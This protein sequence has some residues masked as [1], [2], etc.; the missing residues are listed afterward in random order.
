MGSWSLK[1]RDIKKYPHFDSLISAQEAQALATDQVR[2]AK[3]A[4]FPFIR[5]VQRWNRFAKKGGKGKTK[6]RPI[7]YAARRDASIYSYYRHLL[8][9]R[10]ETELGRLGLSTSILAYRRIVGIEGE[11]GKCNIHFARDAILKIRELRNCCVVAL[12]ISGFFEHLDHARLKALWCR[13]LG[14][15]RLPPDHFRVFEAITRYAVVDKKDAYERLGYI[16]EKRKTKAGNPIHGYLKPY[17]KMPKQLCTG[18]EF[19]EKLVGTG[20]K[21]SIIQKNFKPFGIPQGAPISDLLANLYLLDFDCD[22]AKWVHALGGV[23]YRYSDDILIIVPGSEPVGS[24][25]SARV[26]AH[27]RNF[28]DHLVIKEEKSSVFAFQQ[29][30]AGQEFRLISGQQGR[31]GIEYLG[32]RYDGRRVYIRDATLSNLRRKVARGA[33]RDANVA[34][35]RYPD[36]GISYLKARFDYERL[37]ARFGRVEDFDEK[38]DDYRHWTFW[39]YATRAVEVFGSIGK[40]IR[41]QLKR[42]RSLIRV[43]ADKECTG[44]VIG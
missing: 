30:G 28:G 33:R 18:K 7:R 44:T 31:N 24:D 41:D 17:H 27:I 19:R 43:R 32:F 36:K 9:E 35:R 34:A 20:S 2:V 29:G 26:R 16:G 40:S 1:E 25:L 42:H 38:H 21:K 14:V 4:F 5:Y 15:P 37:I 11:G 13:M 10:Y 3:H 22:V 8:S 6:E 39:T 12:D 23:Y